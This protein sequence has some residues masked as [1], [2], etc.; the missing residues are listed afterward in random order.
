[1]ASLWLGLRR[2]VIA[3][4][5]LGP[6][7][8]TRYASASTAP[9]Q[10]DGLLGILVLTAS[11]IVGFVAYDIGR[12]MWRTSHSHIIGDSG[13]RHWKTEHAEQRTSEHAEQQTR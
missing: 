11:S 8:G 9:S 7:F 2:T 12:T 10:R 3:G 1:M 13:L 4:T 6:S 5:R